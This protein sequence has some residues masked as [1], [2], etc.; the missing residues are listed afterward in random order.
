MAVD[1]VV[2][3]WRLRCYVATADDGSE[4]YPL[5]R[6]PEG[7]LVYTPGGW[8]AAQLGAADRAALPTDD[9]RGGTESERAAAYSSYFAYCGRYE[10]IDNA[11]V[12]HVA[13]CL[14]PNWVGSE[15][16][17]YCEVSGGELI[18][19]TPPIELGGRMLVHELRW[20]REE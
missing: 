1:S 2:G 7:S 4:S 18:H 12:H 9:V 19:R 6:N 5:G 15:Q 10:V 17:R 8:M 11:I 13:M 20:S 16:V 14:M 3:R